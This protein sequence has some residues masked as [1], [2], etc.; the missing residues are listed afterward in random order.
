MTSAISG[1][2]APTTPHPSSRL[3]L[4]TLMARPLPVSLKGQALLNTPLLNKGLAFS[5]KE[6]LCFELNGLL[7]PAV[8]SL[9]QQVE[10]ARTRVM[11]HDT[12]LARHQE[13][14]ALQDENETVFHAL[15]NSDLASFMPLVYTPGVGEACQNFS[16]LWRR[17][18]GLFLSSNMTGHIAEILADPA[19]DKIRLIIMTDGE[20]ILG[21]GDL[22]ANGMGIPIGKSALYTACAGL[23]PALIL[24]VTLD[25]GTNNE[26]LLRD[27]TYIGQHR[28]RL[29]PEAYHAFIEEVVG[30]IRT[31]WPDGLLHWEDFAG[32]NAAPLLER[33]RDILCSFNDDIQGTA[34]IA[35]AAIIASVQGKHE[36]LSAQHIV[37]LGGGSAGCGIATQLLAAIM[38]EGN[39]TEEEACQRF[40]ILDR[41]GLI[42]ADMDDLTEGQKRFARHDITAD[43]TGRDLAMV[44][45]TVH[46]TILIGVSG[47]AGLFTREIIEDM[48]AHCPRPLIFPLSNPTSHA[49]ARPEDL[50]HWTEGRALVSTGSPF[51]PVICQGQTIP[52]DQTNNAYIFPGL[53]LGVLACK[54]RS[55]S[56]AMLMQAAMAVAAHSPLRQGG[57]NLLPPIEAMRPVALAVARAVARQA[58]KEGLCSGF[59]DEALEAELSALSWEPVYRL[60]EPGF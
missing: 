9:P 3:S 7:T 26:A 11:A 58:M 35:T 60:Y 42:T 6:R 17:P 54:A 2:A 24:P 25:V 38:A 46:P 22:G 5:E 39:L 27:A 18:R 31:R 14:R 20:R 47:Q 52:I 29:E 41:Y 4:A 56:D 10:A 59:D 44:V 40:Y 21:L 15:L 50:L 30:A 8:Q 32:H 19:Y 36:T 53:G 28:E 16:A 34:A 51:P 1:N 43:Q 49:E 13:L 55:V 48:A 23:D 37:I 33:Y 57:R 45:K 12:I